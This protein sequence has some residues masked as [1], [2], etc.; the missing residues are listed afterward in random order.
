MLPDRPA[1]RS[2]LLV[3]GRAVAAFLQPAVPGALRA[4]AQKW[5]RENKTKPSIKRPRLARRLSFC[6]GERDVRYSRCGA[7]VQNID[8]VFVSAGLIAANDH[9]LF[10]IK[11]SETL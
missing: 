8:D 6:R 4:L 3:A 5:R 1:A 11:L 9:R 7:N 10:G 2:A